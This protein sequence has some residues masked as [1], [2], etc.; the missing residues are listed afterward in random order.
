MSTV[1]EHTEYDR[2]KRQRDEHRA[3]INRLERELHD[4]KHYERTRYDDLWVKHCLLR[5]QIR[6]LVGTE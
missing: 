1:A 3:T 2:V 5:H 4:L 6:Q